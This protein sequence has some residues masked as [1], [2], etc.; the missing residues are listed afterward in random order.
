[1]SEDTNKVKEP[2]LTIGD[3]AAA[4]RIIDV[5]SERGAFKGPELSSVGNIRDK[6][7]AF[8]D[9]HAPKENEENE[10]RQT[11]EHNITDKDTLNN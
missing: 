10:S 2:E 1:M 7:Q 5:A 6:Y 9:F 8:I 3:F 4:I 11:K